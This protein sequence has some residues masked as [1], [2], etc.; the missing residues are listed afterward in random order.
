MVNPMAR[1]LFVAGWVA[2]ALLVLGGCQRAD[3]SPATD[4]LFTDPTPHPAEAPPASFGWA[5]Q[6][7]GETLNAWWLRPA[8]A[9]PFPT[10]I[11]LHGFPGHERN[12]DLARALQRSGYAVLTFQYRGAWGSGGDFSFT[13]A[14][15]DTLAAVDTVRNQ[16]DGACKDLP[17]DPERIILMGHSMGGAMAL[18]AAAEGAAANCVMAIDYW[19]LGAEAVPLADHQAANNAPHPDWLAFEGSLTGPGAP[20]RTRQA[21]ALHDDLLANRD[22]YDPVNH[23]DRLAGEVLFL[24]SIDSNAQHTRL[25]QALQGEG[26]QR[27]TAA[28]WPTDH[29]FNTARI[30]LARATVKWLREGCRLDSATTGDMP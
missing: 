6:V 14:L 28:A 2:I 21:G 4:P 30:A 22:R 8:G 13:H 5:F 15:E 1:R 20:L 25:V 26:A 3:E 23:A 7:D 11:L 17:M 19:N 18:L 10:V 27:L 16:C 24:L 9:G 29:S 12:F